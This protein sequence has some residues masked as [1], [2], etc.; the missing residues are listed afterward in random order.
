MKKILSVIL[1][2]VMLLSTAAI[3]VSAEESTNLVIS[4]ANDLHYNMKGS[5][6][7]TTKVYTEDYANVTGTGQ[8]RLENNILIDEFLK[9]VAESDSSVVLIPGDITDNGLNEEHVCMA[10]KFAAFEAETGK[11]VYVVPGNHDFYTNRGGNFTR[12]EFKAVYAASGY[13]QAIA[14]DTETASYVAEL[15]DEYRLLALDT[16]EPGISGHGVT[17]ELVEWIEVQAKKAQEDG[18]NLIAIGHHNFLEHLVL[19]DIVHKGSVIDKSLGLAELFA[20][21]NIKYSFVGHTHD[22]DITSYTGS[23]GNVIYDIVTTSLNAYPCAYREVSFGENV[24]IET[25]FIDKIDTT[26]LKGKITDKTYNLATEDFL[27]YAYEIFCTGIKNVVLGF[28]DADDLKE[29]AGLDSEEDAELCEILDTVV[30][31]MEEVINMPF[32]KADETVE[33]HSVESI[34]EKYGIML[35]ETDYESIL[36]LAVNVYLIH[37]LGDENYGILSEEF[38]LI[39]TGVTAILAYGLGEVNGEQYAQVMSFACSFLGADVPVDFF[40]YAG[41]GLKKAEGIDIF[42]SAILSPIILEVTTDSGV[43]DNNATL[44]GYGAEYEEDEELTLWDKIV[45][46]FKKFIA[47]F[48]RIL[49]LRFN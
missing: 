10:A 44:E 43:A 30:P 13:A 20:K 23:N 48:L 40:K 32:K 26:A 14:V 6:E 3:G 21:Y 7:L 29:M 36:D 47:Y 28:I 37:N 16:T 8:L 4:V 18:K 33:G 27:S 42:V 35:P 22:Q 15:D 25:K 38:T 5:A 1:S 49:G 19:S 17:A 11:Q 39:T 31:R 45:N 46:F 9:R 12:D 34:C 2:A 24:S 41:S